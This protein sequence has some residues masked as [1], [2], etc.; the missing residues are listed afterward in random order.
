MRIF[1]QIEY[2]R[3]TYPRALLCRLQCKLRRYIS[4]SEVDVS[5]VNSLVE[6]GQPTGWIGSG[7]V[8]FSQSLGC[9]GLVPC[10]H[11]RPLARII[12]RMENIVS[13]GVAVSG[14][15]QLIRS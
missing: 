6:F 7:W 12:C 15:G 3:Y 11:W 14:L 4:V 1:Q 13:L 5:L 2:V 8:G 9:A 10:C